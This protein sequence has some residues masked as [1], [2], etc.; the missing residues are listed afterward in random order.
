MII[1]TPKE[2]AA[3]EKRVA[4]TPDSALQLHK[5][6]YECM[7]QS[8]AGANAG[9]PDSA[10]RAAGV[11]VAKTAAAL[12]K[13]SDIITK[14]R[15]PEAKEVNFLT[16]DKLLISFFYPAQNTDHMALIAKNHANVIAMDMVP[17]ISRAQKMDALSSMANIAGYR[18]VI[19]AGNNFGRFLQVKLPLLAKYP[20]QRF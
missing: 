19:E 15:P 20:Q 2:I 13:S 6:G 11:K 18:S 7:I 8:G 1:G 3:D 17:R 5:L 14:V 9:F 12:W 10:Y 16:Q 4:M